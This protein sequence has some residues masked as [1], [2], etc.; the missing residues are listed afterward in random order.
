MK[1]QFGIGNLPVHIIEEYIQHSKGTA[2]P[3]SDDTDQL[4]FHNMFYKCS[5]GHV[6]KV[7]NLDCKLV[8]GGDKVFQNGKEVVAIRIRFR[9]LCKKCG[10]SETYRLGFYETEGE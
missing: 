5:C 3:V 9:T 6:M 4:V 10:N 8:E 7:H 1:I 2:I